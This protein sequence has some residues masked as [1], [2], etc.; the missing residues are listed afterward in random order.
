MPKLNHATLLAAKPGEKLYTLADGHGLTLLIHPK[1][2]KLWVVRYRIHG[3][4]R[5]FAAG[6]FPEV[7]LAEARDIC[8][9]VRK[10]V[11]AG[12]DPVAHR[13]DGRAEAR[14]AARQTFKALA[15]SWIESQGARWS[16]GYRTQV[17]RVLDRD[18]F[19]HIGARPVHAITTRSMAGTPD[20]PGWF[21]L[22]CGRSPTVARG[23]R[24][25]IHAVFEHAAAR[26]LL[27]E[28]INPAVRLAGL[29]GNLAS[30]PRPAAS[31]L[32]MAKRVLAAIEADAS[33]MLA[34]LHRFMVLTAARTGEALGAQWREITDLD[35]EA[36]VWVLPK[37][38]MKAKRLHAV[39]LA[40]E[41]V[42][43]LRAAQ[44][45]AGEATTDGF[46][47]SLRGGR[48]PSASAMLA[49]YARLKLPVRHC[50]H[51]WRSTFS[52]I[53]N[54]R[55]PADRRQLDLALAHAKAGGADVSA[56]ES[57]YNRS[58]HLA[59]RRELACLWAGYILADAPSAASLAGAKANIRGISQDVAGGE[60]ERRAA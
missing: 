49:L 54:E 7:G 15:A 20:A 23:A 2:S 50:P 6:P 18:V 17:E 14:A 9:A 11:R 43:V 30:T 53:M 27:G 1:G 33:P 51:G 59:R 45:L 38:R 41:A 24:Q 8:L 3:K 28:Q 60:E 26:G 40:P 22:L 19:P 12:G 55:H 42:E 39:P 21:A 47:F 25:H 48:K 13:R 37:A 44:A 35:G 58:T 36:P 31:D 32:D 52:T 46:V 29:V 4:A 10:I 5:Q 16:P 56:V 34:L 57:L